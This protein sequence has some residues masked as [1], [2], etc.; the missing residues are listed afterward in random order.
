VTSLAAYV[1]SLAFTM[2]VGTKVHSLEKLPEC[3][4]DPKAPKCPLVPVCSEA[5]ILCSPPRWEP[6]WEPFTGE[7]AWVRIESKE[8]AAKR[9]EV[10]SQALADAAEH[11]GASWKRGPQDL[12]RVMLAASAWSTG[13]REDIQ[14]GR[15]RGP[16][17]E[18]CLVD[19]QIKT[20]RAWLPYDLKD[21]PE[22][23]LLPK[24]AGRDYASLRRCFDAGMVGI[25]RSGRAAATKC[26]RATIPDPLVKSRRIPLPFERALFAIY[27]TG[28]LCFTPPP[29]DWAE[30]RRFN[31]LERFRA[32]KH[33]V[34]P[35]W[36][37]PTGKAGT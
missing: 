21:L 24:S 3:G 6:R 10:A 22:S 19:V 32:Q 16:A 14:V 9:L 31:T 5:S 2:G 34:F 25:I 29:L 30:V 37:E 20:L 15:M 1:L 26:D 36:Y 33:T 18:V 8:A 28:G 35:D 7:G 27:G 13:L 11:A 12:A 17:G 23:E 4:L